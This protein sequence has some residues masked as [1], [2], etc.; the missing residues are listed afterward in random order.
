[1]GF[2][3]LF[4][5][6]LFTD[7]NSADTTLLKNHVQ[8]L[9]QSTPSRNYTNIVSLNK[10]ADYIE[11]Q[12]RLHSSTIEIQSY[13]VKGQTYKNVI[14]SF[15]TENKERI[16]IGAHYD[17]CYDQPGADDNASGVAVLL[18]LVRLTGQSHI[19]LKYRIDFVAYTLEEPPFF[20]TENMGSAVHAK[21]MN[22][23]SVK[24]KEM[25]SLETLGYF[26]DSENSQNYPVG[27]L[28]WFYPSK[29]NFV[30]V[31]GNL[32]SWGLVGRL[33]KNIENSPEIEVSSI[34]AFSSIPGID[35]SDHL[36][37]WKYGYDAVMITDTAFLRNPNYHEKTDTID[38]LNFTKISKIVHGLFNY[39][40][41]TQTF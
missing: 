37:Y 34:R 28:S 35:F 38:T 39:I 10:A 2:I 12:F 36:N 23:S 9:S 30:A 4:I 11:N 25:I 27:F 5:F 16:I 13:D 17:V 31:V 41:V 29:G 26:T 15:G 7:N 3:F 18:E 6:A 32:S 33:S 24:V 22:D 1:M 40:I 20:R 8:F 19:K 14:C 21:S